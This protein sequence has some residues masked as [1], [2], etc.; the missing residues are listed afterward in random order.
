MDPVNKLHSSMILIS[1]EYVV[2]IVCVCVISVIVDYFF[3]VCVFVDSFVIKIFQ[4][5]L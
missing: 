2:Y 4:L 1:V 5:E 3:L